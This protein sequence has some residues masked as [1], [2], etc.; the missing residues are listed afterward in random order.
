MNTTSDQ[1]DPPGTRGTVP[2][3]SMK[4]SRWVLFSDKLADSV[5]TVGGLTVIVA[6]LGIM[7]FLVS[8]VVPLFI[9]AS[10]T[11][12]LSYDLPAGGKVLATTVDDYNTVA[13]EITTSGTVITYHLASGKPLQSVSADFAGQ[14]VT[15]FARTLSGRDLAFGLGDGSIRFATLALRTEVLP[16]D[17]MPP[18]LTRLN[19]RDYTDGQNVYSLI[20]G[21]Q[22]RR[23]SA[24]FKVE[25]AQ[26]V[27]EA[28]S[29]IRSI[30][31]RLGGTV[32]RPT[33]AFVTLDEAGMV[34]LSLAETRMNLLTRKPTTKI[35]TADLPGVG[36]VK[37][38]HVLL[39]QKADQVYMAGED[40]TVLRYDTRDF[41][42]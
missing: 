8:V 37:V 36:D 22:V 35:E 6:V 3:R 14:E 30:D 23:I 12:P 32:E 18:G 2:R 17:Q 24:V 26:K 41:T 15:A 33:R 38:S 13:A 19:A 21:E 1:A 25:D 42:Q 40:G 27:S 34:R 9:G 39:T 4:T 28:G 10:V 16:A 11:P 20:P 31:Y 29:P 7:L 5:I